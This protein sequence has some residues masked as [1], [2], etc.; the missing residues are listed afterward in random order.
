MAHNKK[1]EEG[2]GRL[3]YEQQACLDW[4]LM[5]A[6][7]YNCF[8]Y[9]DI[10]TLSKLLTMTEKDLLSIPNF[11]RKSLYEVKNALLERGLFL[12][13]EPTNNQTKD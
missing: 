11:G 10:D 8:R 4:M 9:Y 13:D 2:V 3:Y 1:R 5:S 6:R 7:T 12:A